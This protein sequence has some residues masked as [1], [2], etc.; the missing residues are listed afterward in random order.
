MLLRYHEIALKQRRNYNDKDKS[1][2][3]DEQTRDN[4]YRQ[5]FCFTHANY[6]SEL[7]FRGRFNRFFKLQVLELDQPDESTDKF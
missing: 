6:L 5:L 4:D 1:Y 7:N 2:Y 3:A